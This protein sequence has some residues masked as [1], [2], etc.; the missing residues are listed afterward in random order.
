[1]EERV[2]RSACRMCHGVCQVLVH[3]EGD[4]VV[5]V[6]GDPKSLTSRGYICSKGRAAPE[7]LYH[8]DRVLHPLRRTGKKKEN[9]WERVSWE[10]AL[11]E[12]AQRLGAIKEESGSEYVGL[13]Q[14][15]GRP[16]ENLFNRFA[17][18]FGTPNYTAP[19]H[20]CYLPR[21]MVNFLTMGF[22]LMPIC[23]VYGF[24]GELPACVVIWGCNITET[25]AA[26][27]M[28]GHM[29][30]RA[31]KRA[32]KV[33]VVDPRRIG[34]VSKAD[35]WLQLRPGTDGALVLAMLH[36]IITENL[37]DHA[38]V[39]HYTVGFD[40]LADHVKHFTPEWA[41][42]ITRVEG[43]EIRAAARTYATTGPACIQWGNAI[44]Q[45]MC[46]FQTS[47][48]LLILRAITGNLDRPGT[49]FF[50]VQAPGIRHKTPFVDVSF[51]GLQYLPGEKMAAK[52]SG[53]DYPII[54]TAQS[55]AFWRSIVSGEP[56]RM[57]AL[58]IMGSNPLVTSTHSLEI[59]EALQKLEFIVVS[60][61]FQ[62]P[63]SQYADIFLPASTWLEYD[64]IHTS[65]GHTLSLLAR[66][67][68]ALVGDTLDDQEVIIRMANRL[69][70]QEAFPWRSHRELSEWVLEGTGVSFEEFLD[71]GILIG[72]Q[73]YHKYREDGFFLTPSGKL[74][75]FCRTLSDLGVSPL[76][77]YREPPLSPVSTP[78]LARDYPLILSTGAKIPFFFHG[79]FRM[80]D[81]LR[82]RNRDPLVEIHPEMA[83]SL[84]LRDGDWVWVESPW[85]RVK[86][87]AKFFDGIAPEVV[88]AQHAWWFP[89]EGPPDYGWRKSSINLLFGDMDYDPD[90]GSESLRSTLCRIYKVQGDDTDR[91]SST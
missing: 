78:D 79:E 29:L 16:Y 3:L 34:P 13:A 30:Q 62:T 77:I 47:R 65:G 61:M 28:C 43:D 72:E 66:R 18:A 24:G 10:E 8:P 22:P 39:D 57:R 55:P 15:T 59:E 4:R 40:K 63:T 25:G 26:D 82:S 23:D 11:D 21:I 75:I 49:D 91:D 86:M 81:S 50:P 88:N 60:D 12:V 37:V 17:N 35:H 33:I 19:A 64:E 69:G 7:L 73:R 70:L 83:A 87:R 32:K 67:K 48:A 42:D 90:T 41:Q 31:V 45:S 51:S 76:P 14:G 6:T 5:K 54:T 58:W 20:I 52:V 9:H 36:V 56:Y 68:V 80:L 46:N 53:C 74:E 84:G 89:E 27:G 85:G 38:F 1:V 71:K 44:D 2:V